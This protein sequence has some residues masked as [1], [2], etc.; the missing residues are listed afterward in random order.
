VRQGN[1]GVD[2]VSEL[3][4]ADARHAVCDGTEGNSRDL[5]RK[6]D[7]IQEG[8]GTTKGVADNGDLLGA[9]SRD[10]ALDCREDRSSSPR[11]LSALEFGPRG[12]LLLLDGSESGVDLDRAADTREQRRIQVGQECVGISCISLTK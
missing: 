7:T 6:V 10:G 8:D 5:E 4:V 2:I 12:D 9:I 3:L 11:R 1:L